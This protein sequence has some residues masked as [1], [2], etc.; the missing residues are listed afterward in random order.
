MKISKFQSDCPIFEHGIT[1]KGNKKNTHLQPTTGSYLA[2]GMDS[3]PGH[4]VTSL[5]VSRFGTGNFWGNGSLM[6]GSS[7]PGLRVN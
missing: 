7:L 2:D 6:F 5:L 4:S 1:I 3:S